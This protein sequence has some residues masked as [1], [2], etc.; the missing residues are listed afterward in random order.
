MATDLTKLKSRSS[1]I[2]DKFKDYQSVFDNASHRI[3]YHLDDAYYIKQLDK[4]VYA[5]HV[6]RITKLIDNL[7]RYTNT[8]SSERQL[9]TDTISLLKE[10][11]D[12]SLEEMMEYDLL[13]LD[14]LVELK[15]NLKSLLDIFKTFSNIL[16]IH[17]MISNLK[18]LKQRYQI[19]YK[20]LYKIDLRSKTSE[21]YHFDS[22][23][24]NTE[25]WLE[26]LYFVGYVS[27]LIIL[28]SIIKYFSN[29]GS[30][31]FT[32]VF[33]FAIAIS[34]VGYILELSRFTLIASTVALLTYSILTKYPNSFMLLSCVSICIFIIALCFVMYYR[35]KQKYYN[36]LVSQL[37]D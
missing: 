9:I 10:S 30:D 3:T 35:N 4:N 6:N 34:C 8:F 31:A 36:N 12:Q 23:I 22:I 29:I 27:I 25:N 28:S 37:K 18:V 16:E 7:N 13:K 2:I 19:T 11:T 5:S 15:S 17:E 24:E 32:L 1:N 14:M 20:D 33:C 26:I 21:K